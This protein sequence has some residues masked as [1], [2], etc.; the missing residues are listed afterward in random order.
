MTPDWSA[1]PT[2]VP[3]A[4]FNNPQSLNLYVYVDDNS[5]SRADVDGHCW[6]WLW[7]G[8]CNGDPSP[9]PTAPAPAPPAVIT[10][11]TPQNKLANAQD[12]ARNDPKNQPVGAP[13][14]AERKTFCNFATCQVAKATG[15]TTDALV[16]TKGIPNLANT[17]A[18]TLANSPS[19]RVV[20]SDEAQRLANQG[21][22]VVGVIA[23]TGHGHIVTVRPELLPGA[24]N[25]GQYG[26]LVNNVGA[27]IGV[28]NANDAFRGGAR[29]TMHLR[30]KSSYPVRNSLLVLLVVM[31]TC[32]LS[33]TTPVPKGADV[34][35]QRFDGKWWST[36]NAD[37]RS[38]FINGV[39]DCLTWS[40]HEEG[41]NA[42]PGQVAD[43]IDLFYKEHPDSTNL[44]VVEVWRRI[45]QGS[46]QIIGTTRRGETW[47]NPHWYL[48]GFW[49]AALTESERLGFVEGYLWAMH[50]YVPS[51][52]DKY[53]KPVS[54]Y[55]GRIDEFVRA[56]DSSKANREAVA[57]ILRRY[58]D[59]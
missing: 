47:K 13:G 9:P 48:D 10:P 26:P 29:R 25:V 52:P 33:E 43:K 19:W 46:S 41:F 40:A 38:G 50:T 36:A 21:V 2:P 7:G 55:V 37:E 4:N 27:S 42:T 15:T 49:W 17:D 6:K 14:S 5:V 58:R 11:G 1:G 51:S 12:A 24:Q 20:T 18:K 54:F 16:N 8:N 32:G 45:D 39:A 31:A 44:T 34:A 56:N 53:S 23:E 3:Y 59:R 35:G 57:L 28:M 30:A 22:T